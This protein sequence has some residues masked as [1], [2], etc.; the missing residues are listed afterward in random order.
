MEKTLRQF[1]S[2]LLVVVGMMSATV[3]NAEIKT[4][5]GTGRYFTS[6]F[7][8]PDIAKKRALQRAKSN[9]QKQADIYLQTY[10]RSVN[11]KITDEEISA[12]VNNTIEVNDVTYEQKIFKINGEHVSIW[13]ATLTTGINT[14]AINDFIKRDEREKIIIV[15]QNNQLQDAIEKNDKMIESLKKQRATTQAD[16]D[17]IRKQMNIAELD[18]LANEKFKAALKL[19]YVKDY[20]GAIKLNTETIELKPDYIKAYYNRGLA[21]YYLKQYEQAILNYDKAVK[22]N[23]NFSFVYN[24]RGNAYFYLKQY[25]QAMKNYDKALEL[26]PNNF[27]A[28]NGRGSCYGK[29]NQHEKS[30]QNYNK[31]IELNPNFTLAY[32]NRGSAYMNGLKEYNRAIDDYNKSIEL[33]PNNFNSYLNRGLVYIYL[34]EYERA[35]QD[36]N[37]ALEFMEHPIIYGGRG[38]AYYYL[39]NYKQALADLN[40]SIELGIED[41][42]LG[43]AL[44]YRGLCYQAIGYNEKSTADL[45]K[46]KQLGYQG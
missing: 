15:Q 1:L 26:N 30:I 35:I 31:A 38:E 28:Y 14:D 39:K 41:K 4:Y 10:S 22:L 13:T 12:V 16:K 34:K 6:N 46:A 18:F 25:D 32:N 17:R 2:V 42:D 24:S 33:S 9:A 29:S 20:N 36:F 11:A 5:D 43:E 3:V 23:T 19:Y 27:E 45:D 21:Y 40:K 44:Y 8:N 7:E 37:K